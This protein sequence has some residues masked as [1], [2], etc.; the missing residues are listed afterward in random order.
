VRELRQ[1][2]L[3]SV[4]GTVVCADAMNKPEYWRE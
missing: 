4:Q 3:G 2:A 1:G